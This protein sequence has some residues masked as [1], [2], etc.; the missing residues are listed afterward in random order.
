MSSRVL[1]QFAAHC[2]HYPDEMRGLLPLLR[3]CLPE[4]GSPAVEELIVHLERS[5]AVDAAR[6]YVDVFDTRSNRCPYLTWFTD[7]DT[8]KR[9]ASLAAVKQEYRRHG[10]VPAAGELPDY[11]PVLLEFAAHAGRPGLRL[12]SR[13]RAAV[14]MLHGNLTRFGTPYASIVGAVLA[15]LPERDDA[16]VVPRHTIPVELVGLPG[17]GAPEMTR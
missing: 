1:Y 2:L 7:G 4:V 17:Y 15:T 6:H 5:A 12:L 16:A 10:Y 3:R 11:L 13:F 8:R 9:G 14:S